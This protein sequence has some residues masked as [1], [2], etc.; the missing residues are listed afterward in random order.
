MRKPIF[1]FPTKSD[2]DWA[3]QQQKM[4]RDLK[5]RIK[6]V[7]EL[8]RI[9]AQLICVFVFAYAKRR[10]SHDEAQMSLACI[11]EHCILH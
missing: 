11:F 5:F 9:T 7:G 6:E 10:F 4:A 3:V 8:Y 2:T 1:G